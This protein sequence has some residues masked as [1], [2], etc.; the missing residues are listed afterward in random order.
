VFQPYAI[1]VQI[2]Q[3][4]LKYLRAQLAN[5][6]GKSSQPASH[7][8]LVQGLGSWEG[9]QRSLYGFSHDAMVGEYV[10]SNAHNFGL[11]SEFA[12][13]FCPSYFVTQKTSVALRVSAT[14]YV[15]RTNGLT[16]GSSPII[17]AKGAQVVMPQSFCLLN[18]EEECTLLARGEE[19]TTAQVARTSNFCVLGVQVHQENTQFFTDQLMECQLQMYEMVQK[20]VNTPL[21]SFQDLKLSTRDI[22]IVLKDTLNT[23]SSPLPISNPHV[24]GL[25]SNTLQRHLISIPIVD[26]VRDLVISS[27]MV[28]LV[29]SPTFDSTFTYQ[30]GVKNISLVHLLLSKSVVDSH[31]FHKVS[32]SFLKV[33]LSEK[34]SIGTRVAIVDNTESTIQVG[35]HTPKVVL[36]DIGAQP[37]IPGIQFAKKMGMLDSK[38]KKIIWQICTASGNV[39]EVLG[40]NLDLITL[41]F[42]ESTNQEFCLQVRCLVTN[43]TS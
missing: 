20:F 31:S 8:Q 34:T 3:N 42:N 6:K 24:I 36:L 27:S 23:T 37:V 11:T 32:H 4:E 21:F 30:K 16:S 18:T 5:L 15:I 43:A 26:R 2:L 12:T 13:F 40:K 41:N 14:R 7:A 17:R 33:V 35:G 9:P 28:K 38:L 29:G 39:D 19:T 1:Q 22:I 25:P 10:L